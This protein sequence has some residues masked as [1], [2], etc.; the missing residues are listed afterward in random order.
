ADALE[1]PTDA[2]AQGM[3]SLAFLARDLKPEERE[4]VRTFLIAQLNASKEQ[5]RVAAAQA[6]GTLRDARS[7]AVL[8]PL[9]LVTKSFKDPVREAAEKAIT[10]LN[11]EQAKPQELKAVWTQMQELQRKAQELEKQMEEMKKKAATK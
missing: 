9:I 10:A 2:W 1:F 4:P 5:L 3:E 11:A 7:L 6:L 8:T